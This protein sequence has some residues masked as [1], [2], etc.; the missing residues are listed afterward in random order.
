MGEYICNMYNCSLQKNSKVPAQ[1]IVENLALPEI[2]DEHADLTDLERRFISLRIPFMKILSLP[3][4]GQC[5]INGPCVNVP[6]KLRDVYELFSQL[7][8]HAY[9]IPMKLKRKLVYQGH[10]MFEPV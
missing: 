10:H 5:K 9:L 4:G 7:P 8:V 3:K 6:V 2:L 1:A